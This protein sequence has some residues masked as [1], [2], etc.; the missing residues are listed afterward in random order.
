[1]HADSLKQHL[2]KLVVLG[3]PGVENEMLIKRVSEMKDPLKPH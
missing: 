2:H 1:M 3:D